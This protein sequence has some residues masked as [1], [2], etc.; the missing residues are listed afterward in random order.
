MQ[1]VTVVTDGSAPVTKEDA[2]ASLG[3]KASSYVVV[4]WA[5]EG[6]PAPAETP[7]PAEE[8]PATPTTPAPAGAAS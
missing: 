5:K 1:K 3:K 6:A 4:E 2:V 8:K 7:K